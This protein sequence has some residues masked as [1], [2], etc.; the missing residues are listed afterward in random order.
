MTRQA[1][2]H[3]AEPGAA[4]TA[5]KGA[6]AGAIAVWAMDRV[7]WFMWDRLEGE[8]RARTRSVRPG[9]EPPSHALV[10]KFERLLGLVLAPGPHDTAGDVAHYAIG[11]GPAAGYALIRDKLPVRGPT[12]GVLYGLGVFLMQDE[13]LN[14]ASG[15]GAKPRDYPWQAHARGLIA[16]LVYGV[17]TELVLDAMER[18]SNPRAR[19]RV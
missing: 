17:T 15:L 11:I 2:E 13:A 4:A 19:P 8:T 10:S 7:D 16:H 5:L 6:V 9:G 3:A 1:N 14:A 12:R 18:T